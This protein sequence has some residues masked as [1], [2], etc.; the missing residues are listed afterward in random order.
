MEEILQEATKAVSESPH[1][2]V[3]VNLDNIAT[4]WNAILT[5]AGKSSTGLLDRHDVANMME[6]LKIA[7]RYSGNFNRDDYVDGAGYAAVAY[8]CR[9]RKLPPKQVASEQAMEP[10]PPYVR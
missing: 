6:G 8:A 10:P 9:N 2:P 5:T 4:I 7:R 3:I 1:G